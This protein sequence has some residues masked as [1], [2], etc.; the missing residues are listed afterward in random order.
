MANKNNNKTIIVGIV[1]LVVGLLVGF[2]IANIS[3]TG[4]A[5]ISLNKYD[6]I[7]S[8]DLKS[9]IDMTST[10]TNT[11]YQFRQIPQKE[12][13]QELDKQPVQDIHPEHPEEIEDL[14]DPTYPENVTVYDDISVLDIDRF[15]LNAVGYLT[16][17]FLDDQNE[18]IA[19]D[20]AGTIRL[21]DDLEFNNTII[22]SSAEED[23]LV[24]DC[25]GHSITFD[26]FDRDGVGVWVQNINVIQNCEILSS[27]TTQWSTQ[28]TIGVVLENE[29]EAIECD[30]AHNA[31]QKFVYGFKMYDT[32]T[33]ENC[34][35]T[36][37]NHSGFL[38]YGDNSSLIDSVSNGNGYNGI[39]I[40]EG[41]QTVDNVEVYGNGIGSY[42][43]ITG[44]GYAGI[45]VQ[46]IDGTN[47]NPN[48]NVTLSNLNVHD[49]DVG[50]FLGGTLTTDS[51][52]CGNEYI[53]LVEYGITYE[54]TP[55]INLDVLYDI[56]HYGT[57]NIVACR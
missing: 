19:F 37:N 43:P 57:R 49:N 50:A 31:N 44:Q 52:F 42:D 20:F 8:K 51:T 10:T 13:K 28:S 54:D 26:L 17:E 24:L 1:F 47:E 6:D 48:V 56:S 11:K 2:L 18:S 27:I 53:D 32:S 35:A 22:L 15:D 34:T 36:E 25:Q 40:H 9:S 4:D 46:Q 29:S 23:G 41:N 55:T 7:K 30:V 45:E 3:T 14:E 33:A 16:Q 5:K 12:L 38:M 21:N 39:Y